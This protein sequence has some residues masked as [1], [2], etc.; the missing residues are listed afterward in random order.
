MALDGLMGITDA[1][2]STSRSKGLHSCSSGLVWN[3][4]RQEYFHT[5]MKTQI[6]FN[7]KRNLLSCNKWWCKNAGG[8]ACL[9]ALIY[10]ARENVWCPK[11]VVIDS[12]IHQLDTW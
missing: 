5:V 3:N 8:E 4:Y 11:P 9:A 2:K 7:L 12:D 10:R 6:Q 1:A